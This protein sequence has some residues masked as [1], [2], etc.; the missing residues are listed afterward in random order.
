[1]KKRS[2]AILVLGLAVGAV[3]LFASGAP[4][5]SSKS[6]G[7]FRIGTSS[8]IDSLNPYVAFN[9]DA[10]STFMYIYPVLIQYDA[11]NA[12]F[13]PDFARSWKTS[14]DGKTWTFTTVAEREVVGR[15][16][17]D[18]RGR[19][20]DDQ[21]GHQVQGHRRRERRRADRPHQAGARRRTRRPSSFTTRQPQATSSGSS[22]NSRSFRSTSGAST[23]A[24]RA[25]T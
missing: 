12:K 4:G 21:H 22:S 17:P 10:Y 1:M 11:P 9:Q 8:R 19:R 5:S 7:T 16:A 14:K 18:R 3:T 20:V 23:P 6:G 15:Q 2:L 13:V 25:T 24:T